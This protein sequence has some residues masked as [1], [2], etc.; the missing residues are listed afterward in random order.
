MKGVGGRGQRAEREEGRGK[1]EEGRGKREEGRGKRAVVGEGGRGGGRLTPMNVS[2]P[3]TAK[4]PMMKERRRATLASLGSVASL[5]YGEVGGGG[6]ARDP[7]GGAR[8]IRRAIPQEMGEKTAAQPPL[9]STPAETRRVGRGATGSLWASSSAPAD[10]GRRFGT[11]ADAQG[12]DECWHPGN[13][14]QCT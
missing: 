13:A 12:G 10:A 4:M 7:V 1:R 9:G 2:K 6:T 5:P 14:L 3:T 8:R 11:P